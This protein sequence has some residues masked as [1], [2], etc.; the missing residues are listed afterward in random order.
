V[1]LDEFVAGSLRLF[2]QA[3]TGHTGA[4][5]PAQLRKA[6]DALRTGRSMAEGG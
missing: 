2:D 6:T 4:I 1:S 5:T 3:D